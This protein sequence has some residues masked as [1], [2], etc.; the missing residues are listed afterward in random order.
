M[1]GIRSVGGSGVIFVGGEA[2][3]FH[4]P[5][6]ASCRLQ[7]DYSSLSLPL[8]LPTLLRRAGRAQTGESAAGGDLNAADGRKPPGSCPIGLNY[9]LFKPLGAAVCRRNPAVLS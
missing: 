7:S 2:R 5:P 6:L 1:P 3:S 4:H 8:G 9:A